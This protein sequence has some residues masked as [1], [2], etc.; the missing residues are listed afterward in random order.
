MEKDTVM[1]TQVRLAV[2]SVLCC[3]F[4]HSVLAE[5]VE[6]EIDTLLTRIPS[7]SLIQLPASGTLTVSASAALTADKVRNVVLDDDPPT[8]TSI[9]YPANMS[10]GAANGSEPYVASG[11][12]RFRMKH[13][14]TEWNYAGW[15]TW[16]MSD[17]ALSHGFARAPLYAGRQPA[18]VP[19]SDAVFLA[20]YNFS[21]D[22]WMANHTQSNGQPYGVGRYDQLPARSTL[23]STLLGENTFAHVAGFSDVMLDMELP[24]HP[25]S[26]AS[27][28]AQSWYPS[29]G[30]NAQFENDYYGGYVDLQLAAFETAQDQGWLEVGTYGWSPF[31]RNWW[32]VG[33]INVDPNTFWPWRRYGRDIYR[34][35]EVDVIYPSVYNF[36]WNN[37]NVAYV[38]A[39]IDLN[40]VLVKSETTQKPVRPYFWNQLHGGG[41]G[42]RW[43]AQQSVRNEDMRAQVGM[44]FFSD[45]DGMVLWNWSGT[46]NPHLVTVAG[47]RD[48][49]VADDFTVPNEATSVQRQMRR[50]D[51]IHV[52]EVNSSG[53]ARFQI[54]DKNSNVTASYGT[55][56]PKAPDG[57]AHECWE[58]GDA[59]TYPVYAMS[60]TT[61]K[62]HLRPPTESIAPVIE[63][64]AM[65]R[66][67]EY[68]LWTGTTVNDVSSQQQFTQISPIVRRVSNGDYT[69]V[70]TYDPQWQ[71]YPNGRTITLNNFD[72]RSGLTVNF[73]AD[74]EL[75]IFIMER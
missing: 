61:L 50:Y 63:G 73:P 15:H 11:I 49:T 40:M 6:G 27:L 33:T 70:A 24:S 60:A 4:P 47:C 58:P 64:L 30:V 65:A 7:V 36:Y 14:T 45:T 68:T 35:V 62:S 16:E 41:G 38:L 8:V 32:E 66:L 75:R 9:T 29:G 22:G 53:V 69:I 52:L 10:D 74:K 2:L 55:D 51:A 44:N 71:Q 46:T 37:A 43:W 25:L 28:R 3:A 67:L 39:N 12:P 23:V 42:W 72:A 18:Q 48:Y 26:E 17:Y 21:W 57:T 5:T 56:R 1:H 13:F 54:I 31:P 59:L 19:V 20:Q 34:D